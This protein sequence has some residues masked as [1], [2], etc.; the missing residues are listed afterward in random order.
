MTRSA[1]S[2]GTSLSSLNGPVPDGWLATGQPWVFDAAHYEGVLAVRR[3]EAAIMRAYTRGERCLM[4]L[5]QESLDDAAKLTNQ[6]G[7]QYEVLPIAAA[8]HGFEEIL[9][10]VFAG[11]ERDVTEENLQ[12]RARG[13]LLMAISNK[14]GSMVVTT[15]NS[16]LPKGVAGNA[17]HQASERMRTGKRTESTSRA[18]RTMTDASAAERA[19]TAPLSSRADETSCCP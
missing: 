11:R 15:G 16:A 5:L 7:I 12:A 1:R 9:K 17:K 13:V 2:R 18:G 14:F 3:R 8:V 10:P 19:G 6:L 4:Q